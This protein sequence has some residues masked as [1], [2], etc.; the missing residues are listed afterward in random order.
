MKRGRPAKYKEKLSTSDERILKVLLKYGSLKSMEI[1]KKFSKEIDKNFT[2]H[3]ERT[4]HSNAIRG[5]GGN[6]S[7]LIEQEFIKLNTSKTHYSLTENKGLFQA[8][9]LSYRGG[10]LTPELEK[11][12]IE[13]Y[14][15]NDIFENYHQLCD[16]SMS[17]GEIIKNISETTNQIMNDVNNFYKKTNEAFNNEFFTRT[18]FQ[19]NRIDQNT[20]IKYFKEMK[21]AAHLDMSNDMEKMK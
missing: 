19:Y 4:T 9:M 18:F 21:K 3:N 12:L 20:L 17:Y 5:K 8:I 10:V 15:F 14:H 11:Y 6:F 1:I 13:N 2:G 7:V 16:I